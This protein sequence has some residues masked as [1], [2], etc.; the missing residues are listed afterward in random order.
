MNSPVYLFSTSSHPDAISIN[1][2]DISFFKP[3]I[4]SSLYEYFIL[5]SKQSSLALDR[6]TQIDLKPAL[7]IS[8][9]TKEAYEKIGGEILAVGSGY[10]DN[11]SQEIKKYPK[12]TKWLYIRGK[13]IASDFVF[14]CKEEGYNIDEIIVY[15]TQ[16]SDVL[17]NLSIEKNATLIFTSPS[18]VKCFLKNNTFKE[19]KNVIVIG[20]TTGKCIPKAT[21]FLL[22]N[23]KT[24]ASCLELV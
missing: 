12:S 4:D 6:Y 19:C 3:E 14:R 13:E 8:R 2:L 23:E 22:A 9:L 16:C 7:C 24:I 20:K 17:K 21:S 18:S 10:G 1:S 15:K 11:L 5:T